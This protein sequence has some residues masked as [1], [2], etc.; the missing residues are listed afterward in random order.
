[1][2]QD[3]QTEQLDSEQR[4]LHHKKIEAAKLRRRINPINRL[5]STFICSSAFHLSHWHAK[6]IPARKSGSSLVQLLFC[7]PMRGHEWT[8]R[9]RG[10]DI[11]VAL[12]ILIPQIPVI[13]L[14]RTPVAN[15]DFRE[16]ISIDIPQWLQI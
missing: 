5:Q 15:H 3:R 16:T 10:S 14:I 11:S 4:S 9:T 8:R 12:P 1:M 6:Q 13:C 2:Q 7:M